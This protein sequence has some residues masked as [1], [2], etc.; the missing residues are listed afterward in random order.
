MADDY[1][2][3]SDELRASLDDIR[4]ARSQPGSTGGGG[5]YGGAPS[6]TAQITAVIFG[7]LMIVFAIAAAVSIYFIQGTNF[8]L[9]PAL[10][11]R[12]SNIAAP[13][14]SE[15]I[16]N[17]NNPPASLISQVPPTVVPE[18]EIEPQMDSA[19][20]RYLGMNE[21]EAPPL[22]GGPFL[23]TAQLPDGNRYTLWARIWITDFEQQLLGTGGPATTPNAVVLYSNA[24]TGQPYIIYDAI[25]VQRP[26]AGGCSQIGLG[27][28]G[29]FF[30]RLQ[31]NMGI[32]IVTLIVLGV[33]AATFYALERSRYTAA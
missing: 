13:N 15:A 17:A 14:C 12:Q 29:R 1:R 11:I 2:R 4:A 10:G 8:N 9:I 21:N 5:S 16:L 22:A 23:V 24:D 6:R 31:N 3:R 7:S 19:L 30:N 33:G 18:E 27:S 32:T 25:T 26:L 28:I 20:R